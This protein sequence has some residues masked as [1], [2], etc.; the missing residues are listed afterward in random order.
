MVRETTEEAVSQVQESQTLS[1]RAI[2]AMQ[3]REV[4]PA[5]AVP[6]VGAA[7][8]SPLN[9]QDPAWMT[10]DESQINPETKAALSQQGLSPESV[11]ADVSG[12]QAEAY[13]RT[14]FE[15]EGIPDGSGHMEPVGRVVP[16][17]YDGKHGIDLVAATQDQKPVLMEVKKR[18]H[19]D[20]A[21]LTGA[22]RGQTDDLTAGVR[23]S[24]E[25]YERQLQA[26]R[27][28][29]YSRLRPDANE[30][31]KPEVAQW[32]RKMQSD[33][34]RLVTKDGVERLPVEQM[35]EIWTKDRYIRLLDSPGG[36]D[37]LRSA[38]VHPKYCRLDNLVDSGGCPME[39][40]LWDDILENRMT[41]IVSPT[42]DPAGKRMLDQ[43]IFENK[44][45]RVLKIGL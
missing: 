37:R 32:H 43:A 15:R 4:D 9:P 41:V 38:G 31:W 11:A 33:A 1:P 16:G 18:A 7:E 24:K 12:D 6:T 3:G 8:H 19:A 25:A 44:S 30:T 5:R 35:D 28:G 29:D 40:P 21:Y 20:D 23:E 14:V 27:G 39:T 10:I 26:Y 34:D 17:T 13:A 2:W 36:A 42:D 22:G 45:A